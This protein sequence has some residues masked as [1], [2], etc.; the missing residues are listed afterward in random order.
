[1]SQ[2]TIRAVAQVVACTD[3]IPEVHAI[4]QGIVAP[5]RQEPGCLNYQLLQHRSNPA[6]FLFIEEWSDEQAIDAH[7]GTPHI[8]EALVKVTPLLAQA[9]DIQHYTL[10]A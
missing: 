8:R 2:H 3:K 10:L 7:F 5:T 6:V 1:M 9:P 4:L